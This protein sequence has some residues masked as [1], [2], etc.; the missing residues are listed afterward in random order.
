MMLTWVYAWLCS[1]YLAG[2]EWFTCPVDDLNLIPRT[3]HCQVD[4]VFVV[5]EVRV[6]HSIVHFFRSFLFLELPAR[7][8][9]AVIAP[10]QLHAL[11]MATFT[12]VIAPFGGYWA[13]A[14]KR[15]YGI[16]D[17]DSIIPGHGGVT[18]RMDCQFITAL[19]VFVYR[20]TFIRRGMVSVGGLLASASLLSPEERAELH[21]QLGR[22]VGA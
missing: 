1:R 5:Q 10:I 15:A 11:V 13:S 4:K 18:D 8:H 14:I 2:F 7:L 16:K 21:R 6:P 12:S 17:F 20:D 22:L 19:F 3:L 9:S